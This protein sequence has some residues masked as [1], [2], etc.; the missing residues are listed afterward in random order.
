MSRT[1]SPR[2]WRTVWLTVATTA[3]LTLSLVGCLFS[4]I[5]GPRVTGTCAG[6]CRHYA[7]CK[8]GSTDADRQRCLTECPDVLGDRDSL[9]AY[10]NL[11]CDNAVE[12]IDG[13]SAQTAARRPTTP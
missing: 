12:F 5:A 6:A 4:R 11:S 13:S 8:T 2:S 3:V 10:E 9:M 7:Q 1:G